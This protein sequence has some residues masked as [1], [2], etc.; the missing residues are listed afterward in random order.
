[1]WEPYQV[2]QRVAGWVHKTW[3][4]AAR[5][6]AAPVELAPVAQEFALGRC[7]ASAAPACTPFPESHLPSFRKP[8]PPALS[9]SHPQVK[10]QTVKTS[11]EAATL[12]LRIDDIVSGGCVSLY[13][14]LACCGRA[15]VHCL[16]E[17]LLGAEPRCQL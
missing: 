14:L 1:M 8:A 5:A 6:E 15:P 7:C 2:R 3:L 10:V 12:L 16:W 11:V 13:L 9:V 4:L 17:L